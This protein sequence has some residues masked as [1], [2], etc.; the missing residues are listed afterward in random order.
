MVSEHVKK[1]SNLLVIKEM[2]IKSTVSHPSNPSP[3]QMHWMMASIG[4]KWNKGPWVPLVGRRAADVHR[5]TT[6]L[7]FLALSY[8][9][10]QGYSSGI[11]L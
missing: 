3:R 2:E 10:T 1:M 5:T 11:I 4:G 9:R 6:L 7:C 8:G